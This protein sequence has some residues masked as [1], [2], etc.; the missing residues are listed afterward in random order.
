M[1]KEEGVRTGYMRKGNRS[2]LGEGRKEEI[3]AG[4]KGVLRE[5]VG[6]G[7]CLRKVRRDKNCVRV[8]GGG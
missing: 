5:V 7:L 8:K 3:E 1:G 2:E 4:V 6:W